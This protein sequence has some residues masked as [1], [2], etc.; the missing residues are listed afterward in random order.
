MAKD[1]ALFLKRFFRKVGGMVGRIF[2]NSSADSLA[3][4]GTQESDRTEYQHL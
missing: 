4:E 2:R 1:S 3:T